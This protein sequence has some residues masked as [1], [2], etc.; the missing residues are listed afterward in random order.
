MSGTRVSLTT[1]RRNLQ[2]TITRNT[3]DPNRPIDKN[4]GFTSE[5]DVGFAHWLHKENISSSAVTRLLKD[6]RMEPLRSLISWKSPQELKSMMKKLGT[7]TSNAAGRWYKADLELPAPHTP[8]GK[9]QYCLR[10]RKVE[11]TLRFLLGHAGFARDMIF[12]PY[13]EWTLEEPRR[14]IY[15]DMASA[16]WWWETQNRIGAEGATVVPLVIASDKTQVTNHQGDLAAHAVYLTIG[17]LPGYVRNANNRPGSILLALLPV[18]K[19]GDGELRSRVFHECLRIL[20]DPVMIAADGEGLDIECADGWTRRCF[21]VIA[22]MA[23]DHEEQVKVTGVKSNQHCTMCK[24]APT[25]REDLEGWA[26]W[27]T[28]KD[29]QQQHERQRSSKISKTDGSWVHDVDCFAFGHRYV[30][31]HTT[32]MVD[33]LHQLL[34]GVLMHTVKWVQD[35]LEDE[36]PQRKTKR[37]KSVVESISNRG[38][39]HRNGSKQIVRDIVDKRFATVPSYSKLRVFRHYSTVTQWTGKEQ[40]SLLRQVVPVFSPLLEEVGALH[41][42]RFLRAVVDFILLA[43]YRSHD[44]DTLRFMTL[45]LYRMNQY[46]E[47]FRKY[48]SGR[49]PSGREEDTEEGHFNFPKFHAMVHY[50]DMI[51]RLGNAVELESGHFEALHIFLVK[52]FFKQTNRKPGWEDQI[53]EHNHRRLNILAQ[54]DIGFAARTMTAAEKRE[55]SE[56]AVQPTEA[57]DVHKFF[58]WRRKLHYGKPGARDT[59]RTVAEVEELLGQPIG[60]H[61]RQAAA[62]FVR[63][64]RGHRHAAGGNGTTVCRDPDALES[65]DRWIRQYR[66]RFHASIRCWK[67]TGEDPSDPDAVEQDMVRCAPNWQGIEGNGRYDWIWVQ[68]YSTED[69]HHGNDRTP[70]IAFDG[71]LPAKV[72]FVVSIEDQSRTGYANRG[73]NMSQ[74][75]LYTGAFVELYQPKSREGFADKVHG[76]TVITPVPP[77]PSKSTMRGRR[78]YPLTSIHHSIHVVAT[79]EPG[80]KSAG[81]MYINN[82]VDFATYNMLWNPTWEADE[83]RTAYKSRQERIRTMQRR[84][85]KTAATQDADPTT[86]TASTS[87][88]KSSGHHDGDG[89][90]RRKNPRHGD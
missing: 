90:R 68:E 17:N 86:V 56:Q 4:N 8:T 16:E 51:K 34:K 61:L 85:E 19:E 77:S 60:T 88:R 62:V 53:M 10:Y 52:H 23:I 11:D 74:A 25:E 71:R 64:S 65:D 41:A 21:P 14:R 36:M 26:P 39:K 1:S 6:R 76:M 55:W 80:M 9:A 7:K 75:P 59:W 13:R 3:C 79:E 22:A 12:E 32:L 66:M 70:Q 24:V 31:I 48:R 29:T 42:L 67:K 50:T 18:V 81:H 5:F 28:H 44:D 20:F 57:V 33:L 43:S 58:G 63:E 35:L 38:T 37:I 69:R 54:F 72:R 30:N 49:R 27:R 84:L 45:A 15:T 40:K 46:K 78:I 82:T 89:N 73:D 83:A 87:K 2:L 47:V